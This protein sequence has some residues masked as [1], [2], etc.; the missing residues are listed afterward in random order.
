MSGE[1]AVREIKETEEI[2]DNHSSRQETVCDSLSPRRKEQQQDKTARGER[3]RG[4]TMA[5]IATTNSEQ[6]DKKAAAAA[7]NGVAE[8]GEH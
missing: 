6:M 3:H 7:A 2:K 5:P 1:V 4:I 8:D